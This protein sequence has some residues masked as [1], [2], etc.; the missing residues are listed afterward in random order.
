VK[1]RWSFLPA[2][3]SV[4]YYIL[5]GAIAIFILGPLGGV[6]ASYMNF[7]L[8]FFVGGQ[9]LAGILG[10]VVT[11]GYGP[12]GKH[13]ANYMQTMAA[14]VA[15]MSAMGVLIQAM[16]WLGMP[17][18]PAWQLIIYFLCIGMF[19]VGVGMLYTP[20]LVDKLKLTYPSG[21]AVA[22]ILRALTDP[23][24]LRV[25]VG[26]LLGGIA[27]GIGL[28]KVVELLNEAYGRVLEAADKAAVKLGAVQTGFWDMAT[29][30]GAA[31]FGGGMI[32]GARITASAILVG[33]IGV[34][35]TP[36]LRVQGY[37]GEHDPFRK[38]GFIFALGTILGA[39]I[40]DMGL[41]A[42]D[43][44]ARVRQAKGE[45]AGKPLNIKPL[46]AWV[47]FWGIALCVVAVTVLG[48]PIIWVLFAIVLAFA[49]LM[50]NGISQGITDQN[51]ISSAFVV[52]VL[53]MAGIGLREPLIGLFAGSILLVACT[54]GVD[55]QQ[56]RSTGWRLGSNRNIQFRFQVI[57]IVMGAVLAV[58]MTRV[59]LEAYPVLKENLFAR[60]ELRD[61]AARGWQS[62]MTFKFVGVLNTLSQDQSKTLSVMFLGI[63][64]GL[65]IE[66]VRKVLRA[67]AVYQKWRTASRANA[68]GDFVLDA[69]IF[70][71]PYASSFG[72]FVDFT[73]SLWF[74]LGGIFASTFN[75]AE[76]R[77]ASHASGSPG[78]GEALPEDMSTTSL[79]G[80]GLIA[81]ESLY[82]LFIGLAGLIASGAI[83]KIFGG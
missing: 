71:S 44:I 70:A 20:I 29:T 46:L 2:I 52:S 7:S 8:G 57:G 33:A 43:A 15:S 45:V 32:V 25:S 6:T 48:M 67:S 66:I 11:L 3:G 31:T 38:I 49:F 76:K 73:T 82:A 41:L 30:F 22:N 24:I 5:L 21:L 13:G 1:P 35:M 51:P 9:V 27:G 39:A 58:L 60:P 80:G 59:F 81:G 16:V 47:A 65:G 79:V 4:P 36:W 61:G 23:A 74:G 12:E 78:E 28:A 17:L 19:G 54:V 50:I 18:P 56:D 26:K 34:W 75:W 68:A 83:G 14:S 10:S 63:G 40:V 72:G 55:M 37:L 77:R 42:R 64:V 62:A 53:I 69:L